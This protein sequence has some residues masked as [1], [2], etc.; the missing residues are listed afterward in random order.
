[1]YWDGNY[2]YLINKNNSSKSVVIRKLLN[3]MGTSFITVWDKKMNLPTYM[4]LNVINCGTGKMYFISGEV[5]NPTS[6]S[7]GI[8]Q[9]ALT[10][11]PMT[12]LI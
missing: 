4:G 10:F 6:T 8:E 5:L 1:M 7:T 11:T 9:F 12:K 2:I 3:N